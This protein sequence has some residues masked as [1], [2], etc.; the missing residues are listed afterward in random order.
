MVHWDHSEH[1]WLLM[2]TSLSSLSESALCW[3][4]CRWWPLSS[5]LLVTS[6][7]F[8]TCRYR[9]SCHYRIFEQQT[10]SDAGINEAELRRYPSRRDL[11][12]VDAV[13]NMLC[14]AYHVTAYIIGSNVHASS[15]VTLVQN[16][17]CVGG[18]VQTDTTVLVLKTSD[19]Y[20]SLFW[21]CYKHNS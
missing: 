12:A 17:N 2:C 19:H 21:C 5:A 18:S 9:A 6:Y 15:T 4:C 20:D 8:T 3:S 10:Y 13:L 1:S 16:I 11:N 14:N 7:W